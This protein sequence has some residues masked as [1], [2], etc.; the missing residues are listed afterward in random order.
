MVYGLR[1]TFSHRT[2]M[3]S[4]LAN[5]MFL[6]QTNNGAL[7]LNHI[8]ISSIFMAINTAAVMLGSSKNKKLFSTLSV[9][10]LIKHKHLFYSE[11]ILKSFGSDQIFFILQK[12]ILHIPSSHLLMKAQ[13]CIHNTT[14]LRLG[15]GGQQIFS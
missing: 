13:I 15:G 2:N 9:P 5:L 14:S 8:Q 3:I 12:E 6:Q 4:G 1:C 10:P 7:L 11:I